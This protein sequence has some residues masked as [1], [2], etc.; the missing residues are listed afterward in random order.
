M[1]IRDGVRTETSQLRVVPSELVSQFLKAGDEQERW[2]G[3]RYPNRNAKQCNAAN[4]A[5][6]SA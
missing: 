6:I 4:T 5:Y 2:Q 1:F 3:E